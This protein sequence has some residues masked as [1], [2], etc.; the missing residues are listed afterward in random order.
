[1]EITTATSNTAAAATVNV[2][3]IAGGGPTLSS[4]QR[5]KMM[6]KVEHMVAEAE[7]RVKARHETIPL[8]D[9]SSSDE[10]GS[11]TGDDENE[12]EIENESSASEYEMEMA[13]N[14]LNT[15]TEEIHVSDV[16]SDEEYEQ[17][18]AIDTSH[19]YSN[20]SDN[21]ESLE[22][23]FIYP[24]SPEEV[25]V[26]LDLD[27][28][29]DV[30]RPNPSTNMLRHDRPV[31]GQ[32]SSTHASFTKAGEELRRQLDEAAVSKRS[33]MTDLDLEGS[34]ASRNVPV[35]VPMSAPKSKF[36]TRTRTKLPPPQDRSVASKKSAC[37]NVTPHQ[38]TYIGDP[39]ISPPFS[40]LSPMRGRSRAKTPATD[41]KVYKKQQHFR[42]D[43]PPNVNTAR[44]AVKIRS[45][46]QMR[47]E[48]ADLTAE[49]EEL[50]E[51]SRRRRARFDLDPEDRFEES[52]D[53][54][55]K[56]ADA[57]LDAIHK[58]YGRSAGLGWVPQQTGEA[59]DRGQNIGR[60]N[61][62]L[63]EQVDNLGMREFP[64]STNNQKLG[65]AKAPR[66]TK[67]QLLREL[68]SSDDYV[69]RQYPAV[70]KTPGTMFTTEMVE[71]MGLSVGE[72]AYLAEVMDQQWGTSIDYRP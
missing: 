63:R 35:P 1:M 28:D 46:M 33:L 72:H 2:P 13:T 6:K 9:F 52:V 27:V 10:G 66:K 49:F 68:E 53:L 42:I 38:P 18:K 60:P 64:G 71:V 14:R 61:G 55:G 22:S 26:D 62:I 24:K 19:V 58:N 15:S 8:S 16:S 23:L 67:E 29:V 50:E 65:R 31:V 25:E 7:A 5:R 47:K 3:A 32:R 39:I 12:D 44:S 45:K 4:Q 69:K 34:F 54:M 59:R 40:L 70:P 41:S 37:S 36:G 56:K 30:K 17:D 21:Q 51:K 20:A 43:S 48:M 11:F 57:M